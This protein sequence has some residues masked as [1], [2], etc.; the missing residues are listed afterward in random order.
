MGIRDLRY[1][2]K[3]KIIGGI[4]AAIIITTAIMVPIAIFTDRAIRNDNN[5]NNSIATYGFDDNATSTGL[6]QDNW[7]GI[8]KTTMIDSTGKEVTSMDATLIN[9]DNDYHSVTK[10]EDM[11]S[12]VKASNGIA[13]L[14]N[15]HIKKE[16]E[17]KALAISED[18]G[19]TWITPDQDEYI[20]APLNMVLKVPEAVAQVV[21]DWI[22]NSTVASLDDL[23]GL[24]NSK[25]VELDENNSHEGKIVDGIDTYD[26]GTWLREEG[27]EQDFATA[28]SVFAWTAGAQPAFDALKE[29][30]YGTPNSVKFTTTNEFINWVKTVFANEEWGIVDGSGNLNFSSQL[31]VDGTG[32]DQAALDI[33]ISSF[34]N[35]LGVTVTQK[36]NNHGSFAAWE[37]TQ[38]GGVAGVTYNPDE[39]DQVQDAS[40]G[41][42]I[43]TQ[44]RG[45]FV[46]DDDND[47][48]GEISYWGYDE[49]AYNGTVFSND[50]TIDTSDAENIVYNYDVFLTGTEAEDLPLA[51]TLASDHVVFFTTNDAS[52]I[53]LDG[54]E[55]KPE[56]LTREGYK[57]AYEL[58]LSWTQ[59]DAMGY[60]KYSN[61]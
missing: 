22:A 24:V 49:S 43:G 42:F 48:N 56:G 14:S 6:R 46:G 12:G 50:G 58:G 17:L 21:K 31:L 5:G 15:S 7:M 44:S 30:G 53:S 45:M 57:A 41:A 18:N 34:D 33:A 51:T 4:L 35:E 13:Y 59:L 36:L 54:E 3:G 1:S 27:F 38:Q 39:Y 25:V 23:N 26:Y 29:A 11:M 9:N 8:S 32:T 55:V 60:V 20:S 40:A 37:T 2:E 52:F 10:D 47:V 19:E 28:V 61:I 16:K